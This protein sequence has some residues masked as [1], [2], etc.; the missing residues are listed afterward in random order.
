MKKLI[1][2]FLLCISAVSTSFGQLLLEEMTAPNSG[3]NFIYDF[4]QPTEQVSRWPGFV[5]GQAGFIK[6]MADYIHYPEKARQKQVGGQFI[7]EFLVELDGTISKV[8]LKNELGFG[9]EEE[10]LRVLMLLPKWSPALDKN[11]EPMKVWMTMPV[12]LTPPPPA[13]KPTSKSKTGSSKPKKN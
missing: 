8:S 12:T 3:P 7:A 5:G 1:F 9:L 2:I 13:Q 11:G 6:F 4:G 10:V